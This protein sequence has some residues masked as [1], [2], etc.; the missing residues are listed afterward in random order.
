MK[1]YHSMIHKLYPDWPPKKPIPVSK[2][3]DITEYQGINILRK[4]TDPARQ[5]QY[6]ANWQLLRINYGDNVEWQR[7]KKQTLLCDETREYLYGTPPAPVRYVKGTRPVLEKYVEKIICDCQTNREKV[8]A[9]MVFCRDLYKKHGSARQMFFGGTE[10]EL[11][12]KGENLCE[13]LGRL[14][15]ALCEIA[16]IPGRIVLH[17]TGHIT[18]EVF[19]ENHWNYVDPCYGSVFVDSTDRMLSVEPSALFRFS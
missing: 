16:G 6:Y 15:V 17:M 4:L 12:E 2:V 14:M 8:L 7:L 5:E 9:L 19:F 10:E 11:I 18:S 1:R 13:C 3:F